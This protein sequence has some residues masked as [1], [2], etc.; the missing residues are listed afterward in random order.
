MHG[1]A[2]RESPWSLL[3][4][5]PAGG[6]H[7]DCVKPAARA[8]RQV[9]V[10]RPGAL[11]GQ[12]IH[13]AARGH[14]LAD[15]ALGI[16]Q[17]AEMPL[18]VAGRVVMI[19]PRAGWDG[20]TGALPQTPEYLWK[21]E[22]SCANLPFKMI[23]PMTHGRLDRGKGGLRLC[24]DGG[25]PDLHPQVEPRHRHGDLAMRRGNAGP[26]AVV[27]AVFRPQIRGQAE[28]VCPWICR[29]QAFCEPQE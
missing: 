24:R 13:A 15:I 21:D 28:R 4:R 20:R 12:E 26:I 11:F 23:R 14:K 27:K 5:R 25:F 3:P 17:I 9:F 29:S 22:T 18:V 19:C 8:R 16:A 10:D 6:Q 2:S 1:R 7:I